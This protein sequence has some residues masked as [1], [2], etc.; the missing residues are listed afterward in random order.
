MEWLEGLRIAQRIRLRLPEEETD[1]V[2]PSPLVG[3]SVSE[4][5]EEEVVSGETAVAAAESV[6]SSVAEACPRW[7]L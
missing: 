6:L 4:M 7:T 5:E 2:A 3:M 1:G